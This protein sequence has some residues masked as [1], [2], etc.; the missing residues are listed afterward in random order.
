MLLEVRRVFPWGS[1]EHQEGSMRED[2]GVLA[3][4]YFLTWVLWREGVFSLWTSI[5][6]SA[7]DLWTFSMNIMHQYNIFK[8]EKKKNKNGLGRTLGI[9][10]PLIG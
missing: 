1:R 10:L 4:F 3:M 7:Y 5:D 6:L 9:Y 8:V 2:L